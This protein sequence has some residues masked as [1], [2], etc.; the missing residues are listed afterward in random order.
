MIYAISTT[1][2]S[3]GRENPKRISLQ[4]CC[5][6]VH[7]FLL[8]FASLF[9]GNQAAAKSP[10]LD[11]LLRDWKVM[12]ARLSP[13]GDYLAITVPNKEGKIIL[14]IIP[15][16]DPKAL[17]TVG[18]RG[19]GEMVDA[20]DWVSPSRIVFSVARKVGGAQLKPQAT[21]ELWAVNADGSNLL[22]LNSWR[23]DSK[24]DSRLN[25]NT[26][27][28]TFAFVLDTLRSDDEHILM[29]TT[30]VEVGGDG[31]HAVLYRVNVVKGSRKRIGFGPL[32]N[33]QFL[34]DAAGQ[35][36]VAYGYDLDNTTKIYTRPSDAAEWTLMHDQNS[37]GFAAYPI[38][39]AGDDQHVY[40]ER[41]YAQGPDALM[42][43][44]LGDGTTSSF[45]RD[46]LSDP[47]QY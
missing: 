24:T 6:V 4:Q 13:N 23:G 40:V 3:F 45:L 41:D 18:V 25:K 38:A 8:A 39:F 20:F 35:V 33:A 26:A 28:R 46:A 32:R 21:G 12:D 14:G 31:A 17:Q 47:L 42:R 11:D 2:V 16:A 43:L 27:Q 10:S 19:P 34:A 37:D 22:V 7:L 30:P 36:R 15:I 44:S 9:A 5:S 1:P 29:Y